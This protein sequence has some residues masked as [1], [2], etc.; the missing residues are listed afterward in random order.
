MK[1][2]FTLIEL[3]IALIVITIILFGF[4]Y[5][6]KARQETTSIRNSNVSFERNYAC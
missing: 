3:I 2:A 5:F 1:K 4:L 6:L